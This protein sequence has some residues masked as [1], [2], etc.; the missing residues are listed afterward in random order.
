MMYD[1]WW[2]VKYLKAKDPYTPYSPTYTP[3]ISY[4]YTPPDLVSACRWRNENQ[5]IANAR[6]NTTNIFASYHSYIIN[7]TSMELKPPPEGLQASSL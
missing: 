2:K 1:D 7:A 4:I 3:Q 5:N 6:V